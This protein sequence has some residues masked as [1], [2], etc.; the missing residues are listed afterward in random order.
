MYICIYIY[1]TYIHT[2]IHTYIILYIYIYIYIYYI[3][4]YIYIYILLRKLAPVGLIPSTLCKAHCTY[5]YGTHAQIALND[6]TRPSGAP[7]YGIWPVLTLTWYNKIY[8]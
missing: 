1:Y 4:I 5:M 8:K 7:G 2:Y 3:Y 6:P